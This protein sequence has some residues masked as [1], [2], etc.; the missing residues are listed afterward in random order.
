MCLLPTSKIILY[1]IP[2]QMNYVPS[3]C[4]RRLTT[5]HRFDN[6]A[7]GTLEELEIQNFTSSEEEVEFVEQLSK[8][9]AANLRKV[10]FYASPYDPCPPLTK[11]LCEKVHTKCY[12]NIKVEF[13]VWSDNRMVRFE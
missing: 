8:C 7:L 5:R 10:A 11:N 3:S 6:I 13:Y 4:P 2:F 9:N 12:P 1:F